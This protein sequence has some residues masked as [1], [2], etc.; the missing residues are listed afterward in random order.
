MGPAFANARALVCAFSSLCS[1]GFGAVLGF[2]VLVD[3]SFAI[4]A[5]L[6]T[7]CYKLCF[8]SSTSQRIFCVHWICL[9]SRRYQLVVAGIAAVS[10]GWRALEIDHR[11]VCA[12]GLRGPGSGTVWIK[13]G[14][15][16]SSEVQVSRSSTVT[17]CSRLLSSSLRV[18]DPEL[19]QQ[20]MHS[21]RAAEPSLVVGGSTAMPSFAQS[22]STGSPMRFPGKTC[23]LGFKQRIQNRSSAH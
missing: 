15:P 12:G 22:T 21:Q 18:Q 1:Q 19:W 9:R 10:S 20:L 13:F 17:W 11:G 8:K 4:F 6:V 5:A 2:A 16:V 7:R 14:S 3:V 23:Q